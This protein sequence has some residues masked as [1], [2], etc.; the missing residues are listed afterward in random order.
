LRKAGLVVLVFVAVVVDRRP[1]SF[2]FYPNRMLLSI[3]C[4]VG[5]I[6]NEQ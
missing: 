3:L 4:V 6:P 5:V 1:T 2:G